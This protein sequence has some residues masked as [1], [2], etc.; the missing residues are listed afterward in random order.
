MFFHKGF[1]KENIESEKPI[2]LS[3]LEEARDQVDKWIHEECLKLL[4]PNDPY[5]IEILGTKEDIENTTLS[6]LENAFF[7]FYT[8]KNCVKFYIFCIFV[9]KIVYE[10]NK[11]I[12]WKANPW[13]FL[14]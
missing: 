9:N 3:E 2:I 4:Y 1:T 6:D 10:E 5:S 12:F 14:Q 7:D 13:Q 8:P 11:N